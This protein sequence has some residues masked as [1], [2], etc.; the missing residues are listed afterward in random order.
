M[1]V[2]AAAAL[3]RMPVQAGIQGAPALEQRFGMHAGPSQPL[4]RAPSPVPFEFGEPPALAL[5]IS[6]PNT[7]PFKKH[8]MQPA[9]RRT[10]Q[11]AE[12]VS[13]FSCSILDV[14]AYQ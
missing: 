7:R 10:V 4:P 13:A 14:G 12:L 2:Q 6:K 9:Q 11:P 8:E 5:P 1:Y 3:V